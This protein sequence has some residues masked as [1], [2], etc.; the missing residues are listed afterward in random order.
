MVAVAVE[1]IVAYEPLAA[2]PTMVA[3]AV[4]L[5]EADAGCLMP[6]SNEVVAEAEMSPEAEKVALA[7]SEVAA[8]ALADMT[9]ARF[10]VA[11]ALAL[12]KAAAG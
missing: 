6:A 4:A 11:V 12:I 9:T 1:V 3:A 7:S 10:M 8:L 5:I 2:L